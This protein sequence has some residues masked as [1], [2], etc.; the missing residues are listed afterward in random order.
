M[1]PHDVLTTRN[2]D[3]S[4]HVIFRRAHSNPRA[5][6]IDHPKLRQGQCSVGD[7]SG[8]VRYDDDGGGGGGAAST[9]TRHGRTRYGAGA[10]R[11]PR[12]DCRRDQTDCLCLVFGS[13]VVQTDRERP[14]QRITFRRMT[15][16]WPSGGLSSRLL[17]AEPSAEPFP[18]TR[19]DTSPLQ[20]AGFW[21]QTTL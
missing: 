2:R 17:S 18:D 9:Q 6:Q 15:L 20:T 11:L 3:C 8:T 12:P 4:S 5:G 7:G 10:I 13:A 1:N 16:G 14:Y 21:P 19:P